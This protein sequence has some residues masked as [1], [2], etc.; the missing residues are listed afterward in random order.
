M[1][2]IIDDMYKEPKKTSVYFWLALWAITLIHA[3]LMVGAMLSSAKFPPG[4]EIPSNWLALLGPGAS[5]GSYWFYIGILGINILWESSFKG[6]KTYIPSSFPFPNF[7]YSHV[8][9]I[10]WTVLDLFA[11]L[12]HANGWFLFPDQLSHTFWSSLGLWFVQYEYMKY[13]NDPVAFKK[14]FED[15][16]KPA[17]AK[18]PKP[19]VQALNP[20]LPATASNKSVSNNAELTDKVLDYVRQNGQ[21]KTSGLV[22]VLGS[23]KRTVI[24]NLNKLLADGKL[25]REGSG[26]SAVY[27]INE[28]SKDGKWN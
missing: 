18:T 3:G 8:A 2:S 9:V 25:I 5:P 20:T 27:R 26:Q 16:P 23:S 12:G 24:R 1:P 14:E 17:K 13:L 28:N 7:L 6:P 21:A 19:V 10:L 11:H 15:E 4:Y 22:G